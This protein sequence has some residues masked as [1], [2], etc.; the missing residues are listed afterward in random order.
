[1]IR[2]GAPLAPLWVWQLLQS[3]VETAVPIDRV[4]PWKLTSAVMGK[5]KEAEPWKFPETL[6]AV[7]LALFPALSV[8]VTTAPAAPLPSQSS[9][10]CPVG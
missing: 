5:V 8:T 4:L 9:G 10:S 6:L 7:K 3:P 1:V 2:P